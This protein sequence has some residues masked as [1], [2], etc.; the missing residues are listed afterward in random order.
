LDDGLGGLGGLGG[1]SQKFLPKRAA[2]LPFC[3]K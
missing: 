1:L 2:C 3:Q